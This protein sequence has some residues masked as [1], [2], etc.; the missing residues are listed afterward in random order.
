M[1]KVL[2]YRVWSSRARKRLLS[3]LQVLHVN[4]V[5][6]WQMI[7][8]QRRNG[9]EENRASCSQGCLIT[10]AWKTANCLELKVCSRIL[11]RNSSVLCR[12]PYRKLLLPSTGAHSDKWTSGRWS[13]LDLACSRKGHLD[14]MCQVYHLLRLNEGN[15]ARCDPSATW[16][17]RC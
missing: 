3:K 16:R 7:T 12:A 11:Y 1:N 15:F 10:F 17:F 2:P 14:W 6:L 9:G 13:D 5:T 4:S 8:A